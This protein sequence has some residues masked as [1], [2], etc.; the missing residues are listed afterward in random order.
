MVFA[1]FTLSSNRDASEG[2]KA[3]VSVNYKSHHGLPLTMV[4]IS[5]LLY[6]LPEINYVLSFP[7][8]PRYVTVN[9]YEVRKVYEEDV[10]RYTDDRAPYAW[11]QEDT[12]ALVQAYLAEKD[13][14][15]LQVRCFDAFAYLGYN[16]A[17][18]EPSWLCP[19]CSGQVFAQDIRV[20]LL[21]LG[22][23]TE[24]DDTCTAANLRADGSWEPVDSAA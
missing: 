8:V 10:L 17:T 6:R 20:D 22:I 3:T 2:F 4:N 7:A 5:Q 14:D 12:Q 13:H 23:L 9:V 18:L 19:V 24:A 21:T 15:C 11:K 1:H 16:E